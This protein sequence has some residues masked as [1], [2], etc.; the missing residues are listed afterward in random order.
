[1]AFTHILNES[2]RLVTEYRIALDERKRL[3]Q[4]LKTKKIARVTIDAGRGIN[5]NVPWDEWLRGYFRFRLDVLDVQIFQLESK[6]G[7]AVNVPVPPRR[8]TNV[9]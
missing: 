2:Q 4:F 3:S 6:L 5:A 9:E 7:P 8:A 1:M